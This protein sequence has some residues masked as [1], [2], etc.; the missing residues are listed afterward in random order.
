MKCYSA[1]IIQ[2][3]IKQMPKITVGIWIMFACIFLYCITQ[4]CLSMYQT[5]DD[6]QD[7]EIYIDRVNLRDSHD[8][9]GSR[10]KL[11]LVS[12]K[13]TYYVWYPQSKYIDYA[14]EV[15]NDLLSGNINLV[16]IKIANTQSIRD[17]LFNQK[18]V[19]DI[20]SGSAIYYDLNTEMISMQHHHRTL[21]LLSIFVFMFLLCYTIFISLIYRV[22]IFEKK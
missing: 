14:H 20:R 15:E 1:R 19:V 16:K 17:S 10:M 11:E 5:L 4:L 12:E 8:T 22:L 2:K 7:C 13:T 3:R 6:L 9:K 21:L 18:R